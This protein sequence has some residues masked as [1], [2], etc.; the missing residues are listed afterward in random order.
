MQTGRGMPGG[1]ASR[2]KAEAGV[3]GQ[4]RTGGRRRAD[5]ESAGTPAR[6]RYAA[7]DLGTNNC[8]LL[9]A[10]PTADGFRVVDAFSRIVRLGEGMSRDGHLTEDAMQ[11]A[12]AALKICADKL[13]R[14]RI[15]HQRAVATEACRSALNGDAFRARVQA[16]TGIRLQVISQGEEAQ[17][18]LVGCAPL[19]DP[20]IPNALVFDIGGG[21]TEIIWLRGDA[22]HRRPSHGTPPHGIA[23]WYSMPVGV[24]GLA[25]RFRETPADGHAYEAM[26]ADVG[27]V[28]RE[29]AERHDVVDVFAAGR[30]QMIGTSGTVTTLTGVYQDLPRYDRARVDGCFLSF[31]TVRTVSRRIAAM[32]DDERR[33]HPCIGRNRADFVVPGCAIL[34]AI[35]R[36][37]PVGCLRVA[38]RGLREGMLLQMMGHVD[39]DG[40]APDAPATAA[41]GEQM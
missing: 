31:D 41:A 17:L 25:E 7:I 21:S 33:A 22:G 26:V 39:M 18:A 1:A 16:E 28:L 23:A 27:A 3:T 8:R 38:D 15:I 5:R 29:L 13:R 10:E 6:P 19:L 35:C 34:E 30:M 14:H 4:R 32:R 11:R 40:L 12:L 2:A 37:W 9:V 36:T 24:V 20:D